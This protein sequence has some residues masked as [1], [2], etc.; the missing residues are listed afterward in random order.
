M[1]KRAIDPSGCG[2]KS[3]A[4]KLEGRGAKESA[5][6]GAKKEACKAVKKVEE[7]PV[8]K[9][10]GESDNASRKGARKAGKKGSSSAPSVDAKKTAAV[11]NKGAKKAASAATPEDVT[12]EEK[13]K[14]EVSTF[15]ANF[16]YDTSSDMSEPE[17]LNEIE[18]E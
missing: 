5:G 13:L 14:G 12:E 8:A 17:G 9:V 1:P 18:D 16:N 7:T 2:T 4:N 10:T 3:K 15:L 6:L 11:G